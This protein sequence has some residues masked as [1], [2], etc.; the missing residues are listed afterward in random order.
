MGSTARTGDDGEADSRGALG[1]EDAEQGSKGKDDGENQTSNGAC[2][3]T[4]S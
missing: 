2:R 1:T 4:E 3:E